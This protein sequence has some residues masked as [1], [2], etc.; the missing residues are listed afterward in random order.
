MTPSG[1][2]SP[3][4]VFLAVIVMGFLLGIGFHLADA[5]LHAVSR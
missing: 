4:I 3:G 2:H 5:L 1:N